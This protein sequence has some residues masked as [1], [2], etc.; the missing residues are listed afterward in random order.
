MKTPQQRPKIYELSLES[1]PREIGKVEN[2]L[3]KINR[4]A[5]LSDECFYKLFISSTEAVTNAIVHGNKSDPAK[6]V[7][8]R[9]EIDNKLIV[10]CIKDEGQGFDPKSVP[11]PLENNNIL[12]DNGRGVFLIKELMDSV[13]YVTDPSGTCVWMKLQLKDGCKPKK[14]RVSRHKKRS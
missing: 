10:V 11:N 14:K 13:E 3:K 8:V 2:F 4:L 6:K 1:T 5:R 7:S 9:A 12:K